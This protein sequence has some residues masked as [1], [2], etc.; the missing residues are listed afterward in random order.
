V[1]NKR[2][3]FFVTSSKNGLKVQKNT[4]IPIYMSLLKMCYRIGCAYTW[5]IIQLDFGLCC[6]VVLYVCVLHWLRLQIHMIWFWKKRE[7]K[8]QHFIIYKKQKTK[9][10]LTVASKTIHYGLPKWIV[11]FFTQ[12]K[13]LTSRGRIVFSKGYIG[14]YKIGSDKL[15]NILFFFIVKL[16]C[17]L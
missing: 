7:D 5:K 10:D 12:T 17:C 11:P 4:S 3:I 16:L 14:H 8:Q 9:G 2:R 1:I 13:S 6:F 15:V